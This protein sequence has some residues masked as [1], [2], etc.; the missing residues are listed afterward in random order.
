MKAWVKPEIWELDA[1]NTACAP[2]QIEHYKPPQ[3]HS[4]GG[5]KDPVIIIIKPPK[6]GGWGWC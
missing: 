6:H 5:C 1:K 3:T 2:K 4:G